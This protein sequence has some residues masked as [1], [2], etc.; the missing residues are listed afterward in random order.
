V[1]CNGCHSACEAPGAEDLPAL[2]K[3]L[4]GAGKTITGSTT[5]D[6]LCDKSLV[7]S[8]LRA[9][10]QQVM[11]ADCVLVATCGVGIQ[12]VADS[13][14]KRTRPAC[15]TINMGGEHGTW[16]STER[17]AECGD[18]HLNKTGGICPITNCSKGMVN[19]P[20]GGTTADGKCEVDRKRDCGWHRIYLR[21]K[22]MNALD[23]MRE[24]QP[25]KKYGKYLPSYEVLTSEHWAADAA[26]RPAEAPATGAGAKGAGG[27]APA[28]KGGKH[29]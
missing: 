7:R 15:N 19:G 20:C 28:R 1:G 21:L 2:T 13:V 14:V 16:W 6:F 23:Q 10:T 3:L 9:F 29:E 12:C 11:A 27:S 17:C 8:R 5:V 25:P 4:A 18:C 24:V 26:P 22:E